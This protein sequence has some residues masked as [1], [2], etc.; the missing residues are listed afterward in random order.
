MLQKS[1]YHKWEI[2]V[3]YSN[4]PFAFGYALLLGAYF[5]FNLNIKLYQTTKTIISSKYP[6]KNIYTPLLHIIFDKMFIPFGILEAQ[7][8]HSK[9]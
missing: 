6:N 5:K 7:L 8:S 2:R 1:K 9:S 4:F 3:K